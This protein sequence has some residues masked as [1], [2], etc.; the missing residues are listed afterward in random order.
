LGYRRAS[1]SGPYLVLVPDAQPGPDLVLQRVPEPKTGK[2]GCTWTFGSPSSNPNSRG[3]RPSAL[4]SSPEPI[5]EDGLYWVVMA[6]PDGNDREKTLI[7]S[8]DGDLGLGKIVRAAQVDQAVQDL[9]PL[10]RAAR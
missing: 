7:A 2:T 3:S 10:A 5:D 8:G 4:R 1:S 6:D 9:C